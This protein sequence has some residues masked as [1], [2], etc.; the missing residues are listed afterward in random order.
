[1]KKKLSV[2]GIFAIMV[3]ALFAGGCAS[4]GHD[5]KTT[6]G[7]SA[8]AEVYAAK[9]GEIVKIT[10]T[11]TYSPKAIRVKKGEPVKLEF[12]RVDDKNCGDELVFPKL[13]IKKQLPVGEPVL[14]EFTPTEAGELQFACGMD[15]M[16]GKVV[17]Q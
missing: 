1:M 4:G 2:I 14:V 12:T 3:F 15:M 16:R 7:D 13:G 6:D 11:T 5:H 17:V 9:S 8:D 10:V